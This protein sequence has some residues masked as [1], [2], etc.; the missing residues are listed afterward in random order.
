MSNT[1]C[2]NMFEQ[3]GCK[4]FNCWHSHNKEDAKFVKTRYAHY[5]R[6]KKFLITEDMNG[7]ENGYYIPCNVIERYM[8]N[9]A[10]NFLLP[11]LNIDFEKMSYEGYFDINSKDSTNYRYR[12]VHLTSIKEV[13][14][15]SSNLRIHRPI[16]STENS[17]PVPPNEIKE[18]KKTIDELK[19][20]INENSIDISIKFKENRT[21]VNDLKESLKTQT[22]EVNDLKESLK[23]QTQEVND[24]K[25][26]LKTQTQDKRKP[27][28]NYH[29]RNKKRVKYNY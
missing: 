13:T 8:S 26:S 21:L 20:F 24:L 18:L 14:Q 16:T 2:P 11:S 9:I 4:R 10:P 25:E 12:F 6:D 27:D 29:L 23:T 1:L 19:N 7:D 5:S 17:S 22:Q 28:D 15:V 3:G